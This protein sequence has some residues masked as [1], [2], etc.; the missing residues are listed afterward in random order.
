MFTESIAAYLPELAKEQIR[1]IVQKHQV[2][3]KVVPQRVT[4]HGDYRML[5]SGGHQITINAN[6]NPYRFLLTLIHELA[7]LEAFKTF[8]RTIKPHGKEWKQTFRQLFLPFLRPEIFPTELLPPLAQYFKNPKA[9][10]DT[11]TQLSLA[12]KAFDPT[13]EKNYIFELPLGSDFKIHNGRIFTRG[14]QRVKRYEC[15]EK[16]TG[17]IYLFHPNAEVETIVSED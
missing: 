12:L 4:R 2:L 17:R 10:S 15:K 16:G 3:I 13:N 9:S 8:G 6:L 1:A 7:H 14:A 5:Q 11:D